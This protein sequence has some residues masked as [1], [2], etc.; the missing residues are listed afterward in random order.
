[1]WNGRNEILFCIIY[2]EIMTNALARTWNMLPKQELITPFHT[3][4]SCIS[5][6]A[7]S[8]GAPTTKERI[9]HVGDINHICLQ[10]A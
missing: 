6:S 9:G 4:R 10:F 1:M 8:V 5:N 7:S 3:L 2:K